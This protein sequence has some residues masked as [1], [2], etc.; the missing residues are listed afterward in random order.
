MQLKNLVIAAALAA[1]VEA[2]SPTNS[3]VPGNVTCD[4]DIKLI[5]E[6]SKTLSDNETSWLQKRDPIASEALLSFVQ[7]AMANISSADDLAKQIFSNSSSAPKIGIAASGGG[8]RA[9][10]SGAGMIAAMD[11]RTDGANEHGLGGLLQG[12]TYLAGLSGGNWLTGTL[13]WNNW[14]SVQDILNGFYNDSDTQ[15][16]DL[17]HSIVTPGGI[18][19]FKTGS[20]WDHISDAVQAKQ[21]AG[22]NISLADVWG[23]ALAYNF[24]PSLYRGGVGYT[25][26]T[27]RDADVFK[28]GEMPFPI[29]VADGR[30]PGTTVINLNA[31]VFEFNPFE[32][33][34]WDP[35]LNSFT[36]VKYLGTNVTNGS[37]VNEGKC[38]AGFDNT[39]FVM[40]TSSTLFN[41]FLL[42]LNTTGLPSFI[43]SLAKHFLN[44]LSD[45]YNDIAIYAPNPFRDAD[46]IASNYSQSIA[47]S[48]YLF[49]VDGGEDLENIPLVPLIQ[50][51]RDLDVI[52]ALDNSADTNASWPDGTSLVSTYQRQYG[53][54]GQGM[55]F[56][57]VPDE[58]TFINL[59]LNTRPTFFGC[60]ASNMTDLEYIPPLVVYIP[61][62]YHS[63]NGNQS[64]FKLSYSTDE[65]IGVIQNG[66]EAATR[67]NLTDDSDY[68]GC[69][70][71]AILRRK[72]QSLN[73][74]LPS[75]CEQCFSNYCWNGTL[76]STPVNGTDAKASTTDIAAAMTSAAGDS[77]SS[78]TATESTS[79]TTTSNT[80]SSKSKN[81]ANVLNA[82]N[83]GLFSLISALMNFL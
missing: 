19:V 34:S 52:F 15:I 56:P 46:T 71:C 76:A 30:Y 1:S 42:Q 6:A 31:T 48:E 62:S 44:D 33:G 53:L 20:R 60:D 61:N 75:E 40:G 54:Q 47:E 2:W 77:S 35:T 72:Q 16:W 4:D 73:A 82:Q 49:L 37:P 57:Y 12:A 21:D 32:M 66:F 36:D 67:G 78:G 45:D 5:R 22:F 68:L 11:N 3:Y 18:N 28:N 13:A 26:S 83:I 41:Q 25:W 24:F 70:G 29:S 64:T 55:A 63:Y 50:K 14:T 74:T 8:Y 17:E 43:Q 59:G 23:R 38:I 27:L 58:N 80:K 79:S 81:A 51:Q 69:I 9:M 10:L 39:G 7:R 65:R